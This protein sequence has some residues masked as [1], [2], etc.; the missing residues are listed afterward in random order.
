MEFTIRPAKEKDIPQVMRL[1][2][3]TDFIDKKTQYNSD[4]YFIKSSAAYKKI[5]CRHKGDIYFWWARR[6]SNPGPTD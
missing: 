4:E 5:N 3:T 1:L 2:R 6:D